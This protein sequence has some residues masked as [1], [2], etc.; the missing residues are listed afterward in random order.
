MIA[1]TPMTREVIIVPPELSLDVA[2]LIMNRSFSCS[3]ISRRPGRC[4]SNFVSEK[5]RLE[6]F[7][8]LPDMCVT[9]RFS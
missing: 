7:P 2:W 8:R 3:S 5:R 1:A 4:H 6:T 9:M